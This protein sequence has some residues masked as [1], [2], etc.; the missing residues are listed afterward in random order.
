MHAPT[1]H[2]SFAGV[3]GGVAL[4]ATGG[5]ASISLPRSP[6]AG[7]AQ[8]S[9]VHSEPS[10]LALSTEQPP[11]ITAPRSSAKDNLNKRGRVTG[12]LDKK[13][14]KGKK[15]PEGSGRSEAEQY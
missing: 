11:T 2:A 15:L 13:E 6:S 14:M 12:T 8:L 4:S 3:T 7:A 1:P 9:P 10:V 5:A